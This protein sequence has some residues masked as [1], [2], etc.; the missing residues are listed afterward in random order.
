MTISLSSYFFV[1]Q[2]LR[3]AWAGTFNLGHAI[4]CIAALAIGVTVSASGS[5]ASRKL[6]RV[7]PKA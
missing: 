2:C 4:H 1:R 3:S 5:T 6:R 7:R